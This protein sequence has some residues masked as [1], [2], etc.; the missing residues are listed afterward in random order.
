MQPGCQPGEGTTHAVGCSVCFHSATKALEA[1][2]V[3]MYWSV[4]LHVL[5]VATMRKTFV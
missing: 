2:R 3:Y 4:P 1:W 5:H